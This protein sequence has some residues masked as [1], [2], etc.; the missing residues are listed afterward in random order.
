MLLVM[1]VGLF[2]FN[3]PVTLAVTA[4]TVF[5]AGPQSF[6]LLSA[7]LAIGAL[8]GAL[9]GSGRRARPSIYIVLVAA[10]MFGSLEILVGFA[11]T[12]LAAVALL[13]PTGFFMIYFAQAANQRIQ[14]GTDPEFRG[15]VVAL[16]M[17]VF[18][19]TTPFGAMI[20]GWAAE[21]YGPRSGMWIGGFASLAAGLVMTVVHLRRADAEIG[22]HM[23]PRPHVHV[24]EPAP[25]GRVLDFR[26]PAIRPAAR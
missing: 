8:G 16:Y 4:T 21:Q 17:L 24:R 1:I 2:G 23:R 14:L 5:H 11:P 10:L 19:G 13:I 18:L 6:G 7:A 9:A 15:R 20:T 26:L 12:Y 3:F 22:L 25:D